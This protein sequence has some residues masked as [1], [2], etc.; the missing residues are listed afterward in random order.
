MARV[1]L[2]PLLAFGIGA[3]FVEA[4]ASVRHARG[5]PVSPKLEP[6]SPKKFMGDY[7]KDQ[8]PAT[9]ESKF[10]HPYPTVQDSSNF[11]TDYVKDSNDDG[12]KWAAQFNYDV[13]RSKVHREEK[14]L[15]GYKE[16]AEDE[17]KQLAAAKKDEKAAAEKA[18]SAEKAL[19][20]AK[21]KE[22][23]AGKAVEDLEGKGTSKDSNKIGGE[24]GDATKKVEKEM[25]D[26]EGCQ[27]KLD[28]AKAR[29]KAAQQEKERLEKEAKEKEVAEKAE[30]AEILK[31][32][33]A[34]ES[35]AEKAEEQEEKTEKSIE[36]KVAKKKAEHDKAKSE[37]DKEIAEV[38]E[39][40]AELKAMEEKLRKHRN[41]A[42]GKD[43]AAHDPQGKSGTIAVAPTL[44]AALMSVFAAT[45]CGF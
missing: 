32:A 42:A 29:L 5:E 27:K 30:K 2:L 39:A 8:Q 34:Q 11:D 22:D 4:A 44:T 23:A 19:E 18:I 3:V 33:T 6:E 45:W 13:L 36:D 31:N 41:K 17:S 7:V 25:T 10:G 26:L 37:Y 9:K 16:K 1:L 24:I 15:A 35:K 14:K 40:E 12:G 38:K 28:D 21:K 43:V 20:A